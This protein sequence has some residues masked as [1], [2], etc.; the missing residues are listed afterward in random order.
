M[1]CLL[2]TNA[3]LWIVSNDPR[4]TAKARKAYESAEEVWF[5]VVSLWEIAIKLSVGGFDFELDNDWWRS[6]PAEMSLNGVKRLEISDSHCREVAVLPFR[7]R[8][9]FD[10]MMI[11]QARVESLAVIT[12]DPQFLAYGVKVVW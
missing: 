1:K 11:A 4:L 6:I 10:R 7:H 3:L 5:T 8:D 9:P 2:D 12:A